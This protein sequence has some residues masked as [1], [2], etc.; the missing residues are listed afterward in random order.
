VIF[1]AA[2]PAD[3]VATS[4]ITATNLDVTGIGKVQ[5]NVPDPYLLPTPT[6][7]AELSLFQ[8]SHVNDG[9]Q[10]VTATNVTGSAAGLSLFDQNGTLLTAATNVNVEQGGSTVAIATYDYKLGTGA[11]NDGLYAG[12]GLKELALQAGQT[13]T[14]TENAG[15]IGNDADLA[16]AL[17]GTGNLIIAANNIVSLSSPLN[18]FTGTTQVTSGTL[19]AN[20]VDVIGLSSGVTLDPGTTFDTNGFDQ[21]VTNLTGTGTVTNA[22]ATANM[23]TLNATVPSTFAGTITGAS[24]ALTAATGTSILTGANSY[25]GGTT[26]DAGATLQLG[27]GGFTGSI[28]GDVVNNGTLAFKRADTVNFAGAI[29]GTGGVDQTGPGTT[30]LSALPGFNTYSGPTNVLAGILQAGGADAFSANSAVSVALAGTLDL[31]GFSQTVASL[32]HAGTVTLGT[33]TAPGTVLTVTGAYTSNGGKLLINTKLGDSSSPTDRLVVGSTVMG[34]GATTVIVTNTGG[35]G[36]RTTGNGIQIVEV[37]GASAAGVFKLSAPVVAGAYSYDL[38]QGGDGSWYL[39]SKGGDGPRGEVQ[40]AMSTQALAGRLGLTMLGSYHD[41]TGGAEFCAERVATN[42]RCEA[43]V[44]ARIIGGFGAFNNGGRYDGRGASYDYSFGGLQS[45]VDLFRT[46]RDTVGFY[47]GAATAIGDVHNLTTSIGTP[48]SG[49]AS[50]NSYSLGGYWTHREASGWYTDMVVQ[51][52]IYDQVASS[53]GGGSGSKTKGY[54]VIASFESGVPFALGDGYVIEPQMQ[55]VYQHLHLNDAADAFGRFKYA[56]TDALYGRAGGRLY[57]NWKTASGQAVTTWG[58]A[59]VW[60]AMTGMPE[61]TVTNLEGLAPTSFKGTTALGRA[62]GQF[63]VG[64]SG[65]VTR[66]TSLYGTLDYNT[67]FGPGTGYSL[68]GRVGM[69]VNW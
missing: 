3:K 68:D 39:Q 52:S 6:P 14:L 22:T 62:W 65:Q 45:G 20:A 57:K 54:D 12:Y 51:G 47:A 2:A 17:T 43:T 33:G 29:T 31:N 19:K 41:R 37:Q 27:D 7:A 8:Q 50:L 5:I 36:A 24:M 32:D 69:K 61:V 46:L 64:I 1:D 18:M 63:G 11:N 66:N 23:L 15:A 16:A 34:T 60:Y 30:I 58:R 55:L 44:W 26:I 49:K 10:L 9:L 48:A 4:L 28:L 67:S 21:A 53:L 35:I 40:A 25:G 13:L 59:N 56:D 38:A 42:G